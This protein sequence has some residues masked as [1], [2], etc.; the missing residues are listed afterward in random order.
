MSQIGR[1]DLR[2]GQVVHVFKVELVSTSVKHVDHFVR[3]NALNELFGSGH[4]LTH[5]NLKERMRF[6]ISPEHLLDGM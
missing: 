2:A 3:Q 5:H 4:I 1:S 6:I